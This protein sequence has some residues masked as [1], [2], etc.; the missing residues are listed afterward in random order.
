MLN[1]HNVLHFPRLVWVN[2][3][4]FTSANSKQCSV[5]KLDWEKFDQ[6]MY[7]QWA[8]W[9]KNAQSSKLEWKYALEPEYERILHETRFA[10]PKSYLDEIHRM[11][12]QAMVEWNMERSF[13]T[14]IREMCL[15]PAICFIKCAFK[16]LS[17]CIY[18]PEKNY[19]SRNYDQDLLVPHIL[20]FRFWQHQTGRGL[21]ENHADF[22]HLRTLLT[23]WKR[24]KEYSMASGDRKSV[25]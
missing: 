3:I 14:N 24:N 7:D 13:D 1:F 15:E 20:M 5:Y 11:C 4:T 19:Y 17:D 23:Y 25:V 21:V 6:V 8:E 10:L 12:T 22:D 18:D 9:K 2:K 16:L